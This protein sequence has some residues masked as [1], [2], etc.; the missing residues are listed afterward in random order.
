[1]RF[2]RHGEAVEAIRKMNGYV[3]KGVKLSVSMAKYDRGG[4]SFQNRSSE[5]DKNKARKGGQQWIIKPAF[6]DHRRYA[7]VVMGKKQSEKEIDP[8][9][10]SRNVENNYHGKKQ[11]MANRYRPD[12]GDLSKEKTQVKKLSLQV[13][14][15]AKMTEQLKRAI[16]VD[17][18][19]KLNPKEAATLVMEADISCV[20]AS[21]FNSCS[22]ILFYDSE[23]DLKKAIE[24]SSPLWEHFTNV[25]RW[26]EKD[27]C[28]DRIVVLECYGVHPQCWDSENIKKIGELWGTVLNISNEHNGLNSLTYARLVVRTN[29]EFSID[30]CIRLGWEAGTCD[31]WVKERDN[32]ECK[33]LWDSNQVRQDLNADDNATA[34]K[35]LQERDS[36]SQAWVSET[37]EES[38]NEQ[39][40]GDTDQAVL[41]SKESFIDPLLLDILQKPLDQE[42]IPIMQT[43]TMSTKGGNTSKKTRGRPKKGTSDH[44]NQNVSESAPL[45]SIIEADKTWRIA[46]RLGI[47]CN[48]EEGIIAGLRSSKRLLIMDER[49]P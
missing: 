15:N 16:L 6:R 2:N 37:R 31:I 47:S 36:S 35:H 29:A 21:S 10:I 13:T 25:R 38:R 41:V 49:S 12:Q 28:I 44:G 32:C 7:D 27:V 33:G 17:F 24:I 19:E 14:E 39:P 18:D 43:P 40:H 4:V 22:L 23:S 46:Q 3:V 20:C 48:N 9:G 11:D 8:I 42:E 30:H 1:M 5:M 26:S 34:P 45:P